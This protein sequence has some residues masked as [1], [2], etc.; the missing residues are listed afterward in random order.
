MPYAMARK[1][2]NAELEWAW[3]R[4]YPSRTAG[5]TENLASRVATTS[6]F[7]SYTPTGT[8]TGHPDYPGAAGS[9]GREQKKLYV[10]MSSTESPLEYAAQR[11]LCSVLNM[12]L[13]DP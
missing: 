13:S 10:P 12:W 5:M 3:Q 9:S 11:T 1:Y 8:G 4:V 2:P 7:L 6:I